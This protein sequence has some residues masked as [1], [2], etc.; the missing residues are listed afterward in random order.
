MELLKNLENSDFFHWNDCLE[1]NNGVIP[2]RM[3]KKDTEK[4]TKI[5]TRF[6]DQM[7]ITKK[8][9]IKEASS[10]KDASWDY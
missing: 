10:D 9:Y 4:E 3:I 7:N 6:L 8:W 2:R 1:P 5:T